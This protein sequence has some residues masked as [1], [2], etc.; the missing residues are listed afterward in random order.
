MIKKVPDNFWFPFWIDKWMFGSMRLEFEPSERA[1]WVDLLCLAEKDNGYIRANEETPYLTKQLSGLLVYDE[2]FFDKTIQ[3]FIDKKKL[4]RDERGILHIATYEKYRLTAAHKRVLKHRAIKQKESS[5]VT[6]SVTSVTNGVNQIKSNHNK[7][8]QIKE[9]KNFIIPNWVP[10]EIF[11]EYKK[12]RQ[13]IRK[14]MTDRA[15]ELAIKKLETLKSEGH[16]PKKVLEQSILNSWQGLFPLKE[17]Y[18]PSQVGQSTKKMTPEQ[19]K[20][21]AA[22]EEKRVELQAKY[23]SKLDKARKEG[24]KEEGD[25]LIQERDDKMAEWSREWAGE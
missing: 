13:K 18:K 5:D 2:E 1:L 14:P 8:N 23:K 7:S 20:Y 17:E 15:I 24:D 21:Y 22:R 9:K 10:K 12:M 3:K 19:E 4:E 6:G 25:R 11:K 16:D